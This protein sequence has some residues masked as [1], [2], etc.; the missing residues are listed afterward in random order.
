MAKR[1]LDKPL[2]TS[3]LKGV[4]RTLGAPPSLS[5]KSSIAR[6]ADLAITLKGGKAG[7]V[8]LATFTVA[9]NAS[10]PANETAQLID[11]ADA[12]RVT[13]GARIR[14]GYVFKNV[15]FTEP[16]EK[17]A[18]V[19]RITNVRVNASA[20]GGGSASGAT[21]VIASISVSSSTSGPVPLSA[22][23]QVVALVPSG[24]ITK[25]TPRSIK[26]P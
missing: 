6:V 24:A 14:A 12:S 13:P 21:P 8:S 11:E 19:F 17:A 26:K 2:Q 4:V 7:T 15:K 22:G 10:V 1:K 20:L 3:T 23:K 9:L 5:T 18:R 25:S 16:G